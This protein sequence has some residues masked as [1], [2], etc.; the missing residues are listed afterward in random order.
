MKLCCLPLLLT[1]V[2]LAAGVAPAAEP[3]QSSADAPPG[4]LRKRGEIT[5]EMIKKVDVSM[6]EFTRIGAERLPAG[7]AGAVAVQMFNHGVKEVEIPEWYM[8]DE[9]NFSVFYRRLPSDRPTDPQAPW[10]RCSPKIPAKAR[11]VPLVM[12]SRT[13]AQF[14]NSEFPGLSAMGAG[15][16]HGSG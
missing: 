16:C 8:V 9:Y 12:K 10:L 6:V 11:R 5:S 13:R 15:G 14:H 2:L 4:K 1:A 7:T 3:R